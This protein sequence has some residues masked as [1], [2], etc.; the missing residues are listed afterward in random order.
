MQAAVQMPYQSP[1]QEIPERVHD[2]LATSEERTYA[3]FLHLLL[4]GN[5][6]GLPIISLVVQIAMWLAKRKESP[7]IDDHGREAINFHLSLLLWGLIAALTFILCIGIPLA[8][9]VFILSIACPI[10]MAV[11]TNN[12]EFVRYPMTFRFL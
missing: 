1:D 10:L 9:V 2:S 11:R 6:V 4:L 12:G 7:F 5:F 8:I 3:L